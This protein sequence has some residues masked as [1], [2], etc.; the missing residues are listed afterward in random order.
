MILLSRILYTVYYT[1]YYTL[2][3]IQCILHRWL[4][5]MRAQ[6][7]PPPLETFCLSCKYLLRGGEV[8]SELGSQT[9]FPLFQIASELGDWRDVR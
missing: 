4:C 3:T 5:I 2:Y 1:L 8:G 7:Q 9:V 6:E